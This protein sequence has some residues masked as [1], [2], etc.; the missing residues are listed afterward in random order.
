MN[1]LNPTP[2]NS[3]RLIEKKHSPIAVFQTNLRE[4]HLAQSKQA[5]INSLKRLGAILTIYLIFDPEL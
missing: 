4:T 3:Y 5:F 1:F 2:D